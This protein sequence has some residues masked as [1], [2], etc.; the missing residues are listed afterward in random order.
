MSTSNDNIDFED[1][2][3]HILTP[4]AVLP[5]AQTTASGIISRRADDGP[6]PATRKLQAA[7]SRMEANEKALK[8]FKILRFLAIIA[9]IIFLSIFVRRITSNDV[10]EKRHRVGETKVESLIQYSL[11]SL[12]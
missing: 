9:L 8:R 6:G 3:R 1:G 5:G 12:N 4:D 10:A 11:N 2:L 7:A